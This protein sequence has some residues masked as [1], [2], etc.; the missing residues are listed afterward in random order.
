MFN[1]GH[2]DDVF[3][4]GRG[5]DAARVASQTA[6]VAFAQVAGREDEEDRLRIGGFGE[7][8]PRGG[9]KTGG[10]GVVFVGPNIGPTVV[11]NDRGIAAAEQHR[12]GQSRRLLQISISNQG[13]H[14]GNDSGRQDK[15]T[16]PGRDAAEVGVGS[17]TA[18]K[19]AEAC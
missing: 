1:R 15:K 16:G 13:L 9:V 12:V 8:V 19:R 7:R 14:S 2:R 10:R 18:G 3:G 4:G 11:R 5:R 17:G 6:G